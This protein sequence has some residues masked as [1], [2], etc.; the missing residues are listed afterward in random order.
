VGARLRLRTGIPKR[1]AGAM[2]G[3]WIRRGTMRQCRATRTSD[4]WESTAPGGGT[5]ANDFV[6]GPDD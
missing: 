1:I 3:R 4:G 5:E 6:I 2:R